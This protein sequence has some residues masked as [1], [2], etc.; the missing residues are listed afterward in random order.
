MVFKSKYQIEFSKSK[1][2]VLEN[3]KNSIFGATPNLFAKNFNGKVFENGFKVKVMGT[4][5]FSFKGNFTVNKNNEETLELIVGIGYLDV[6]LYFLLYSWI[7]FMIYKNY[8]KDYYVAIVYF[9]LSIFIIISRY[10]DAKKSKKMFFNFLEKLDK[11]HKV[12]PI[13]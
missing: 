1:G 4:E 6:I 8:E 13:K 3:I 5:S 2:E 7:S 9:G 12:V 10:L 11:E